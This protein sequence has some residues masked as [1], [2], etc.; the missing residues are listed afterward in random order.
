MFRVVLPH[1]PLV[2]GSGRSSLVGTANGKYLLTSYS[3]FKKQ[4]S[5][6]EN[7]SL[8]IMESEGSDNQLSHHILSFFSLQNAAFLGGVPLHQSV[9]KQISDQALFLLLQQRKTD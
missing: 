3:I 8:F 7:L 5:H 1:Y 9:V 4:Q 6:I 2:K